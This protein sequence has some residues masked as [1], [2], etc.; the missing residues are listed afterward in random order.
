MGQEPIRDSTTNIE[1]IVTS[2]SPKPLAFSDY[3]S[4]F[5]EK[6]KP[7]KIIE[8]GSDPQFR[9]ATNLSRYCNKYLSVNLP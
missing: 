8:I 1:L 9:I 4:V 3:M 7:D 6:I 2:E 5:L